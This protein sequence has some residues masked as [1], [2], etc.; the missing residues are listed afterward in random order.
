MMP[1]LGVGCMLSFTRY[2]WTKARRSRFGTD[3][4][5]VTAIEFA[6]IMPVFLMGMLVVLESGFMM[7]TE[8]VLQTSVQEAS[9]LVRTGQ[10]QKGQLSEAAF[11]DK[12]C[13]IAG[14]IMN[15]TGKVKV[16]L[17][18]EADFNALGT[19]P[20][21]MDIGDKKADGSAGTT[22]F[23][24]GGPNQAVALIATY[25]WDFVFPYFMSYF[26]NMNSNKTRRV[27]GF[28]MFR[29]EPFP[30]NTMGPVTAGQC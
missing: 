27:G 8:Y 28:A 13:R 21:Y 5:G 15:C 1:R 24:C 10:A 4:K 7:F 17:N 22:K 6:M 14:I 16:Y 20:S 30:A 26:G 25:D 12:I 11:K 29:N 18:A 9:R 2:L 3:T 19:T 23:I